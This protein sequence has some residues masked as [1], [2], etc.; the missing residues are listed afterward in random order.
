MALWVL[1]INHRTASVEKRERVSFPA[2]E[3]APAL[4]NAHQLPGVR[5]LAIMSTCNRTEFYVVGEEQANREAL[6][7]W[8][9]A[10]LD[11]EPDNFEECLYVHEE[12]HAAR[13]VMRVCCGLDSMV[14]G[15]PQVLGQVK[16]AYNQAYAAGTTGTILSRLFEHA[17]SVAKRVRTD[18]AIGENPV[19]VAY[20]A[21]SMSRH[22]FSNMRRKSALLIGA[23]ETVEL[24]AQHLT[25]AGVS[26][27]TVANRSIERAEQLATR[28]EGRAVTL[29]SVPDELPAVDIVIAS[30]GSQLPI[31]G[32]GAVEEALRRR[33][34][35]PIFMVDLAVP[36][37]I[38]PEVGR[39][40][41]VFLYTVDD[42]HSVIEE[43]RQSREGAA[44]EAEHLVQ[45]GASEFMY[46][47]RALDAVAT[48][49]QFRGD[50][51]AV[52]DAEL[53]KA[54]RSLA[55][56]GDP[57]TLLRSMARSLT[58][59][60][61]HHPTVQVRKATAEGRVEVTDWLRELHGMEPLS[62]ET[63][64]TGTGGGSPQGTPTTPTES[65]TRN[66][67]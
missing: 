36:R 31:L 27:M 66:P 63:E 49:K 7:E 20:A 12:Q 41:D 43:N 55:S 1:G 19:S 21:V 16:E 23:G 24:V 60:F 59:K 46:Q 67:S 56:G 6:V 50:V 8:W 53:D 52:R 62:G 44:E 35:K 45:E 10:W 47:L 15:E 5:E 11:V 18:T 28:F 48:L 34:H 39:L 42:L 17:F 9:A 61:L 33:K 57:E 13:H 29:S 40:S 14:L 37:D 26:S 58:N 65:S 64:S 38:E 4:Q 51:E 22:I 54:L 3:M 2:S 32:K 25:Q 30:T